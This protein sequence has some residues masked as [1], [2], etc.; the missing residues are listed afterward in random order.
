MRQFNFLS[1]LNSWD[2]E[3]Q[4]K[5][6][7]PK[8][9]RSSEVDTYGSVQRPYTERSAVF[10]RIWKQIGD[11]VTKLSALVI[12][13]VKFMKKLRYSLRQLRCISEAF[14][15]GVREATKDKKHA[16]NL[17][18]TIWDRKAT[19]NYWTKTVPETG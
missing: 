4:Q 5:N 7:F 9:C 2:L 1:N 13:F 6:S 16:N 12:S 18:Y 10:S 11:C 8:N 17:L 15:E 3:S 14:N 19:S